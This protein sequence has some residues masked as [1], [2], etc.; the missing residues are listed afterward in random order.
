[1]NTFNAQH[2]INRHQT[3]ISLV[4][5]MVALVISLFLLGGIIQVYLA[6]KTTYKFTNANA[7]VQENGRF[8]LDTITEDL[9][10]A[11]FWGCA[12]FKPGGAS[13]NP[14]LVNNLDTGSSGY[15]PQIHDFIAQDAIEGTENDGLNGS[16]SIT[17]RGAKPVQ[18]NVY[19][20]YNNPTSAALN[21]TATDNIVVND[22]VML[23][24]CQGADIFQVTSAVDSAT[25]GQKVIGHVTGGSPGNM[26]SGPC[27]GAADAHCL[28]QTYG[29]DAAM[30]EL[31]TVTYSIAA[32]SDVNSS[33][34][35]LWRSENGTDVEL[36]EGIE[37]MQILY[38]IDDDD[39]GFANQYVPSTDIPANTLDVI[40][41]R[42]M[43]LVR[44]DT[45]FITESA[46]KYTFNGTPSTANDRRLR[47]VFTTTIALRNRVGKD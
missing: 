20:P 38:G 40:S 1:M 39:D 37:E 35:A 14:T 21:I 36:I 8:A 34:P 6:N 11:G 47:Q 3:G 17:I 19:Q 42:V 29:A 15:N 25:A 46:Q 24:S 9:R 2:K 23:S 12:A 7:R 30:S 33:E 26:N 43:L 13:K 4:E 16:D 5:I 28:S 18:V 27:A 32:S 10:M 44:S 31:Q 22:I 41:V 45:D